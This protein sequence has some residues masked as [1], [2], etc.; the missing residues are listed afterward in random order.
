MIERVVGV[1]RDQKARFPLMERFIRLLPNAYPSY[2]KSSSLPG[3]AQLL[4]SVFRFGR[5]C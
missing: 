3:N 4:D 1:A 5:D 2:V